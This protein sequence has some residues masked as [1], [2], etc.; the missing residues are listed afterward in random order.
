LCQLTQTDLKGFLAQKVKDDN[1]N[2]IDTR[3]LDQD[4]EAGQ[5]VADTVCQ[6]VDW[7]LSTVNPNPPDEN[8]WIRPNI[9][10]CQKCHGDI[11]EEEQNSDYI[12][13][14]NMVQRHTRCSTIKLLSKKE[15]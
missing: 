2:L 8:I 11:T 10:P 13:L 12:G 6:Y 7:L 9:H 4:I 15:I 3:E 5:K 14:L 1:S